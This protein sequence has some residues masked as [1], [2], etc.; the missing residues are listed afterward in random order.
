MPYV[1]QEIRD[2]Y[3]ATFWALK[4]AG[5]IA[6]PGELNYLFTILANHYMIAH[7]LNYQSINDVM[8]AFEGAKTEFYREVAVE[9]EESKKI[10]NGGVY[11]EKY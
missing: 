4:D 2:K 3:N 10:E 1:K 6:S 11:D 5:K 7:G 8:G 9:Y